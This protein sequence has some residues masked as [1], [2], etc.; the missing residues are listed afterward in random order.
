MVSNMHSR[1]TLAGA[2]FAVWALVA[3]SAVYW[4]LKLSAPPAPVPAAPV[5]RTA[6]PA[7]PVSVA[8]LLGSSPVLA[9]A[10]PVASIASRFALLGV[11]ASPGS[12]GAALIAIDGKPARPFRIGAT[13]DDGLVLKFVDKRKAELAA[14]MDGPVLVTLELPLRS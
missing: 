2:T 6:S 5:L 11:V 4:G 12:Q 13:V 9:S 8:R 10:A 3:A 1:W 14:R 7:D